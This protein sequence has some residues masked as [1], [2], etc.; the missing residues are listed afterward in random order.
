MWAWV[1]QSSQARDRNSWNNLTRDGRRLRQVGTVRSHCGLEGKLS[2]C[3]DCL[4][5]TGEDTSPIS[6]M[7]SAAVSLGL[8]EGDLRGGGCC[9]H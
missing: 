2:G 6:R 9:S 1:Q 8:R 4:G 5:L 7:E 3:E